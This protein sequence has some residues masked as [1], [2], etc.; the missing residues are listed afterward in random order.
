MCVQTF[1]APSCPPESDRKIKSKATR[2]SC[3]S[4]DDENNGKQTIT[5]VGVPPTMKSVVRG[6]PSFYSFFS[7]RL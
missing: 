1:K 4:R 7:T 2:I 5:A 6:G 3:T